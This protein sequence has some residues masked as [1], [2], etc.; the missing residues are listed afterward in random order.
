MSYP[1]PDRNNPSS[2]RGDLKQGQARRLVLFIVVALA[3]IAIGCGLFWASW[4]QDSARTGPREVRIDLVR[5]S[6]DAPGQG[7]M[8]HPDAPT[9]PTGEPRPPTP[10]RDANVNDRP[11][12]MTRPRS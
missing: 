11:N 7:V 9:G 10:E 12:V 6:V 2:N 4:T 1:Q 3:A 8:P 5:P